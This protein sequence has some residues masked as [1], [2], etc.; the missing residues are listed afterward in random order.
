MNL[1]S[2]SPSGQATSWVGAVWQDNGSWVVGVLLAAGEVLTWVA[3]GPLAAGVGLIVALTI[4]VIALAR[5]LARVRSEAAER[6]P[7][8]VEPLEVQ[9]LAEAS[10]G[11]AEVTSGESELEADA[12]DNEPTPPVTQED[13]DPLTGQLVEAIEAAFRGDAKAV[14]AKFQPWIDDASNGLQRRERESFSLRL[15]VRAGSASALQLLAEM[16]AEDPEQF[17]LLENYTHA[18]L[19]SAE[20]AQAIVVLETFALQL[21]PTTRLRARTLQ[22]QILRSRMSE[23]DQAIAILDLAS[24]TAEP[25]P[26]VRGRALEQRARALWENGKQIDAIAA[27]EHAVEAIPNDTDLRFGLAYRS[28][29]AGLNE[30]A[31]LHYQAITISKIDQ[32]GAHNNLGVALGA[33]GV[34]SHQVAEYKNA[35]GGGYSLA[36]ANL[37]GLLLD[38]GFLTEADSWLESEKLD[39]DQ[40]HQNV[41]S[42]RSRA[43]N[44]RADDKERR[45]EVEGRAVLI[46]QVVRAMY[47]A[48][49]Q[50]LEGEWS[51][52]EHGT[53]VLAWT[54]QYLAKGSSGSGTSA[55]SLTLE[56]DGGILRGEWVEGERVPSKYK[57]IGARLGT[58]L[59]LV[60]IG[61]GGSGRCGILTAT[62]AV[63]GLEDGSGLE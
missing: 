57:V 14:E 24:I 59:R 31:V 28:A 37:A 35:A 16:A 25:D 61:Y 39:Q 55:R 2:S 46:Q 52:A 48:V 9:A 18:L 6:G 45:E 22:S 49:Q 63:K 50:P 1:G 29:Q 13:G 41:A 26:V 38:I 58:S 34:R 47:G 51:F 11:T 42:A 53:M 32:V 17:E 4:A 62:P 12:L 21:S 56:W 15:Q 27:W 5:T 23:Y 30:L 44:I 43:E 7:S 19:E 54:D 60:L 3:L 40:L 8:E 36:A 33:L 10:E 20:P